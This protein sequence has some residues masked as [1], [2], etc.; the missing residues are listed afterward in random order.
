MREEEKKKLADM[1]VKRDEAD[2]RAEI[3]GA[4]KETLNNKAHLL[5]D[6]V[7]IDKIL[8]ST[9]FHN[10]LDERIRR[11]V[12]LNSSILVS[13]EIL[14]SKQKTAINALIEAVLSQNKDK[15]ESFIDNTIRALVT[16]VINSDQIRDY[17]GQQ[18]VREIQRRKVEP[19]ES[20]EYI[21][22]SI[23]GKVLVDVAKEEILQIVRQNKK[24]ILAALE[25]VKEEA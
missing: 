2:R 25:E 8:F 5:V 13:R 4:I 9:E 15:Y 22:N 23:D 1:E 7:A 24:Y 14:K 6:E 10:M 11:T 21:Q 18:A 3:M 20:A 19:K 16:Q 12:N 17:I